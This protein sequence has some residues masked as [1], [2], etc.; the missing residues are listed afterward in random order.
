MEQVTMIGVVGAGQMGSGIARV[1]AAAGI[2]VILHDSDAKALERANKLIATATNSVRC[3]QNFEELQ[4]ADVI[5][6]AIVESEEVKKRLFSQLDKIAKP[7]AILASNTSSISITR[8]ASATNR[9]SQVIGMHFMNPP[10]VMKVIEIIRGVQ[11]SDEVF[12][13]IKT[14]SERFGKTVMC[15]Q[16]VPGF[17][18]NRILMPMINEAFYALYTG[19]ATKEDI[20]KM[21]LATNHPM[22]PLTLADFIGLDVCLSILRVLHQGLGDDKYAPCPL[23][24]QY[25]DAGR[26]GRKRGIGLRSRS[27]FEVEAASKGRQEP[28]FEFEKQKIASLLKT[29]SRFRDLK[30]IYAGMVRKN[31]HQ[32][33]FLIN[34][35]IAAS[36]NFRRIDFALLVFGQM[37][38]P[39]VVVYN[40]ILKGFVR[41]SS[42]MQALCFYVREMLTSCV[43]PTSFTF[44]SLIKACAQVPAV[45]FGEALHGRTL[46]S[47]FGSHLFLQ[48]GLIDFYISCNKA[49]ECQNVFDEMPERDSVAW[50]TMISAYIQFGDFSSAERLFHE[51]PDRDIVSWNTMIAGYARCGDVDAAAAMFDQMPSKD[52][53]SWTSMISCYSQNKKFMEAIETFEKMKMAKVLPDEVTI[54][55]VI[56]ACAHLGALDFGKEV[57]FYAAQNVFHL[58]VFIGSALIDMYAK[59]GSI[60]RSLLVFFKL[61]ERNIFCWNSMIEGLALHGF[62][63]DALGML[64]KMGR[65]K[66]KPNGVTF[67]SVLS[68]CT[69]AG[70]VE[71]GWWVFSSM[72]QDHLI[73]PQVEHYGCMVDLL[74]RAGLLEEAVDLIENMKMEPNSVIWGALLSGCKTHRNMDIGLIAAKRLMVLEPTNCGHHSLLLNMYADTNQWGE[75]ATMRGQMKHG[76][77]QKSIPGHS[78][79]EVEHRVHEFVAFDVSHPFFDD[80]SRLILELDGQQKFSGCEFE[81]Y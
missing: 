32:D 18:V 36:S 78:W 26:L 56:S 43:L 77:V 71:E 64:T 28:P 41:C 75:V 20:D 57:H 27:S 24:V 63:R 58:D 70:L 48:T 7:S 80:I 76:S 50:S 73:L 5:I 12:M 62:A 54:A 42:P 40:A 44:S 35:L 14:L 2:P 29:C 53:V 13:K 25:V 3:T 47:G 4:S 15:S 69:H 16:D 23:L 68:A 51:M 9:P 19:V 49:A 1:V 45:E 6:E 39:N 8:L 81:L 55:T 72:T 11:T 65:E 59:C 30:L 61:R 67:V 21:K 52:L 22:G 31:T 79:I 46:K 37:K 66:I 33:S 10:P 74:S 60:E 34:L 17:I 38:E